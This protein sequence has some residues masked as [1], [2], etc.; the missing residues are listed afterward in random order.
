MI[1]PA[2]KE[3][4]DSQ[5]QD[6]GESIAGVAKEKL[7]E[8]GQRYFSGPS[9]DLVSLL[10]DYAHDKP[11]VAALWCLGLGILIGWKLRG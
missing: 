9:G 1:V 7:Q 10:K 3:Q 4:I 2:A 8:V 11:D 6:S 5:N